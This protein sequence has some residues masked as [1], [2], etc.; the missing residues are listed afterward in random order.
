MPITALYAGLLT[1]LFVVLSVA[2]IR[3]RVGEKISVGD[4]DNSDLLRRIRVHANFAEY[5]PL[6]LVLLGLAESLKTDP[7]LLHAI[8]AT[9][10][11]GRICHAI[12]LSPQPGI[13][14]LRVGGMVL[15]FIALLMGAGTCIMGAVLRGS[16]AP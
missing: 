15:T 3:V 6:A 16:F 11:I 9:L 8:G 10:L 7:R 13:S 1:L 5:A 4:G 2:V 14:P 12:G